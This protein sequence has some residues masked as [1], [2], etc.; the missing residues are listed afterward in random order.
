MKLIRLTT[1]SNR[2]LFDNY[3]TS[4]INVNPKSKIALKSL[5]MENVISEIVIDDS[6]DTI[7]F[8]NKNNQGRVVKLAHKEY[9]SI[10]IDA[11]LHEMTVKLNRELT[12][13]GKINDGT[14]TFKDIGKS[15]LVEQDSRSKRITIRNEMYK[16]K[17]IVETGLANLTSGE[18]PVT[19]A[20]KTYTPSDL[21]DNL[22]GCFAYVNDYIAKGG[23]ML[24]CKIANNPTSHGTA[25]LLGFLKKNP[26]TAIQG[27]LLDLGE[28]SWGVEASYDVSNSTYSL[29]YSTGGNNYTLTP[30]TVTRGDSLALGLN[31]GKLGIYK[32]TSVGTPTIVH[33]IDYNGVDNL[34]P[35]IVFG[36]NVTLSQVRVCLSPYTHPSYNSVATTDTLTLGDAPNRQ[37]RSNHRIELPASLAEFLGYTNTSFPSGV[38]QYKNDFGFT[39]T[40]ARQFAANNKSDAFIVQMMNLNLNSYD[41]LKR[42]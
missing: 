2:A 15:F 35:V 27:G 42:M 5:S 7:E 6:N 3:F 33:E 31:F 17:D 24:S 21:L 13:D 1:E 36:D 14:Q 32:Y 41:G 16:I 4:E 34:Y 8:Q 10:N 29:S 12:I 38:G 26:S 28:I 18:V 40:A 23:G 22:N 9:N 30:V 25:F 39:W 37:A 11:L 20:N 19:E